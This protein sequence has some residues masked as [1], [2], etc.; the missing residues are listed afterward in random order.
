ME[1]CVRRQ[2]VAQFSVYDKSKTNRAESQKEAA[3]SL[4]YFDVSVLHYMIGGTLI[5]LGMVTCG[6]CP[7]TVFIQMYFFL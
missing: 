3:S 4:F 5:G 1:L 7:G 2:R 6:S